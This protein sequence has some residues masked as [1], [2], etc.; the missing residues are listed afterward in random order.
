PARVR[1]STGFQALVTKFNQARQ[2]A[3]L[4]PLTVTLPDFNADQ[5][6]LDS[7]RG[8]NGYA[9]TDAFGNVLH[10]F[11]VPV[12]ISGNLVA[13]EQP[14]G[15]TA[16]IAWQQVPVSDRPKTFGDPNYVAH[17]TRQQV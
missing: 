2:N 1:Q 14:D 17:V 15:K 11:R 10:E 12:D 7:I 13:A 5:L 16:L 4:K 9:G 8:Y 3:G 6:R